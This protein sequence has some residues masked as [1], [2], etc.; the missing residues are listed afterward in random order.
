MQSNNHNQTP[1]Y[2][3]EHTRQQDG[4]T[5]LASPPAGPEPAIHNELPP[6]YTPVGAAVA[7]AVA[8]VAALAPAPVTG[9]VTLSFEIPINSN[10]IGA[11]PVT[12]TKNYG[13]AVPFASGYTEICGVMGVDPTTAVVGYKWDNER[14][15]VPIHS[16]V[17]ATDWNNC[18]EQGIGQTAR[19]R[20]RKVTCIIKN[21]NLPEETASGVNPTASKKRKA[22][23]TNSSDDRKTCDYTKEY[24]ELKSHL[25]CMTH[26]DLC[27]V[28]TVD[29]HHHRVE[30]YHAS[31]WAKKIY[32]LLTSFESVGNAS[33]KR[34][35]E[36]VVFQDFFLPERKKA[37]KTGPDASSNPCAPTIH[38]TVNTGG[39]GS[40]SSSGSVTKSPPR[41]SPLA[42]ITAA[43]TNHDNIDNPGPASTPNPDIPASLYRSQS[44]ILDENSI[45]EGVHYPPV[46]DI[47]QLIDDSGIFEGSA[48]LTFPAIIFADT[49]RDYQITHVDHVALLDPEFYVD[50]TNMPVEL[51]TL[52]WEESITALGR[53]HKGKGR[54]TEF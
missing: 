19:A 3:R 38:V 51:A 14:A 11:T 50:Q 47:L 15:N 24:R 21:L 23:A 16:L 5:V 2:Y 17:N 44:H 26:K 53:A 35:P 18:L 41:R 49:L 27:F 30:P 54:A 39:S 48:A 25:S 37:R 40:G 34:P 13:R 1:S 22:A 43:S 9:G 45:S 32:S 28:S 6:P 4:W 31:L 10:V 12:R 33:A 7:P 20:T 36:N 42:T 8:P 46:T 29:G 52:F